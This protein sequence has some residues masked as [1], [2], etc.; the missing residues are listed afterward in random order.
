MGQVYYSVLPRS[1]IIFRII[2]LPTKR[3][4]VDNNLVKYSLE[5][6]S[7]KIFANPFTYFVSLHWPKVNTHFAFKRKKNAQKNFLK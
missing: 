6:E 2:V 7:M 1:I 4:N 3:K 5:V